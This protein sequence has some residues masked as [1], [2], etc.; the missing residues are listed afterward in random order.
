MRYFLIAFLAFLLSGNHFLMAQREDQL[1]NKNWNFSLDRD[2]EI[3]EVSIPHTWNAKDAFTEGSQYYRGKGTYS[4]Q[5]K[6]PKKWQQKSIFLK[7]EGSNQLTRVFVNEQLLGEHIGGYTGFIFDITSA[8]HAGEENILRV[9]VDNTHNNDIPP[10]DADFNFYGGI[11]RDVSLIVTGPVHFNLASES[12]GNLLIKTPEV[13]LE[14]AE[15]SIESTLVNDAKTS[16]KISLELSIF[17]PT[18]KK[19][20]TLRKITNLGSGTSKSIPIM[21]RITSPQLWSPDHPNLYRVEAKIYDAKTNMTLDKQTS[22][23]GLRWFSV[24]AEEGFILN[25]KPI[26]LIGANRHQDVTGLGNALPN[27]QHHSD[28]KTI[29]E[30]GANVIR[31]AHYPQDP[32]VYK[33]CDELGL[34]VWSEVPVIND[35]TN[36]EAYHQNALQMQRE[37]I[38]QFYNHPSVVIWG[39]MN[40]IFIQLIFNPKET[41]AETQDKIQTT[42]A[43]AKK[44]EMETKR[45]DPNRLTVMALHENEIYN[46]TGIADIPDVIGWNLYFGW[47]SPGLDS[48]GKFLDDQ[49]SRY[50]NRPLFISEYGP[51]SDTRLQTNQPKPWDYSEAYQLKLHKSYINQVEERDFVFGMTAWNFADFGSD[52][53]QDSRPFINQKGLVNMD[54][55]KKDIY[56]Y[57]QAR[58]L[59]E[60]F[61][62]I[63]GE[64]N[65][66]RYI[67][68]KKD[69][70]EVVVFSNAEKVQLSTKTQNLEAAVKNGIARFYM[71]LTE[72]EHQLIAKTE[73]PNPVSF[74][75]NLKVKNRSHLLEKLNKEAL[76][77]NVGT[78]VYFKDESNND[79]WI[80][81]Q[82][83]QKGSFGYVDGEVYLKNVGKFQGTA[84]AIS[85]TENDPLYQTMREGLSAYKFDVQKGQYKITLLL[86]EPEYNASTENIYNLNEVRAKAI[87]GLRS[88]DISIN[89]TLYKKDLN[90][91]RDYGPLKAVKL[92]FEAEARND[93]GINIQFSPNAGKALLSGI[94]I[95]KL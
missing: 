57:Y 66:T 52:I 20:K 33:T 12:L 16:K 82:H 14:E 64:N 5:L 36:S 60:P 80:S 62:Y 17:D 21:H 25:G 68:N 50:P 28:Y 74:T 43:L 91:A 19:I 84:S 27:D 83:Y 48:F 53:R 11:Y 1:L 94:Q 77:V 59:E 90:L 15:I 93:E 54:R 76:R 10:L 30:M 51:G 79:I 32:E 87:E 46:E 34:L 23:F 85:G 41:E 42:V 67:Q 89:N 29:K 9:E 3:T 92:S 71:E 70:V 31:T 38:L 35:V 75:R 6:I 49:H 24:D 69:T 61:I 65:E 4:R 44:L 63:A 2:Q 78:H 8:I 45:L 39:Y 18:G 58:L 55:S 22:N 47:Y 88:F 72:G 95:E 73:D 7:F 13:N 26:K 81:D 40:E 86:T 37:Q 56:Y